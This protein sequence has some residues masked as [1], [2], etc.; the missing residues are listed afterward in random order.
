MFFK[1]P[2]GG[3]KKLFHRSKRKRRVRARHKVIIEGVNCKFSITTANAYN[4]LVEIVEKGGCSR[5][6]ISMPLDPFKYPY[7]KD[8]WFTELQEIVEKS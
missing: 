5:A 6:L 1:K 2:I 4:S 3:I 7:Y 8:V